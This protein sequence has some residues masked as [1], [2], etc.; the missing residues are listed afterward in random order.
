MSKLRNLTL[1][2]LVSIV[3]ACKKKPRPVYV[4]TLE[5]TEI[6]DITARSGGLITGEGITEKG[7]CWGTE[8]DPERSIG[9]TNEGGGSDGF[10]SLLTGLEPLKNYYV[11]A[12]ATNESGSTY[13][14]PVSFI[15]AKAETGFVFDIDNNIYQ[16]VKIGTKQW[17][18]NSLQVKHYRNGDPITLIQ[19][20]NNW[21]QTQSGA[22]CVQPNLVM[23]Y[24][25]GLYNWYAIN[26]SRN[27]A[28]IGWHVATQEEWDELITHLG[29]TVAAG[30][31]LR[32]LTPQYWPVNSSNTNESGFTALPSGFRV[33]GSF[34]SAGNAA[35]FWTGTSAP[36]GF[37]WAYSLTNVSL[38][39][40]TYSRADGRSVRCVKDQ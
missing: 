38:Y 14:D 40:G 33:N 37:S 27:I 5:V 32:I 15:S 1:I 21:A 16:T 2:I 36:S 12:Y 22:Y 3:I 8:A 29:G 18:Q 25:G 20:D 13:G 28:P 39:S 31:K 24:Y 34:S 30:P 6:K 23:S 10:Q 7:I 17:M 9:K 19:D 26:D 11:W 35:S 4:T